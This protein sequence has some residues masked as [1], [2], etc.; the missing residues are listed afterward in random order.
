MKFLIFSYY[1]GSFNELAKITMPTYQ[2]YCE[3]HGYN[4]YCKTQNFTEGR[5]IGW[6]KFEI[7]LENMDKY[8]WIFYVECDSMLMNQTIR[9]ENLIDHHH[10]II[11]TKT[12]LPNTIDLNCGPMLVRSCE[13]NKQFFKYL[14]NKKEYYTHQLVEQAA[15]SDE[16]NQNEEVRKHFKIMNIRFFNSLY[17]SWHMNSSYKHGDFML[18]LAGRSNQSRFEI[19]NE[20]KQHII[21]ASDYKISFEP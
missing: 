11:M 13:W 18:H 7:F 20:T 5:T 8:D 19:F 14:L 3:L 6:S 2:E 1:D 9:L 4:F 10:D 21:K 16:V 15:L 17:H 12:D